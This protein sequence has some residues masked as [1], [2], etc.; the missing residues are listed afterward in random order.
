[1]TN[2]NKTT[3]ITALDYA[4]SHLTDAPAEIMEKLAKLREQTEKRNSAE[5]KPTK[6]QTQNVELAEVVRE[7]L[8]DSAKPL[9][10]TEIMQAD[11]RFTGLS[12][13]K[14]SAVVRSM[15]DKVKK[16]PDK[17]VSRFTLAE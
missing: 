2:T 1:M 6:A 3:Y 11:E 8:A 17:R 9:T 10:I 15:G 14:I 5:R 4:L 13:Q 12:N 7:V 16:I